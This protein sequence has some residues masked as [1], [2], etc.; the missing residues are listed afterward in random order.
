[1]K[2]FLVV[3]WVL[4]YSISYAQEFSQYELTAYAGLLSSFSESGPKKLTEVS[5]VKFLRPKSITFGGAL[6]I[7]MNKKWTYGIEV[8]YDEFNHGY[9]AMATQFAAPG[10]SS[11]LLSTNGRIAIYKTGVRW[12]YRQELGERFEVKGYLIPS[13]AYYKRVAAMDDTTNNNY[14]W[15]PNRPRPTEVWYMS[16]IPEQ[17]EGI[18]FLLKASAELVYKFKN[19]ISISLT[20]S[21]QQGFADFIVDYTNIMKPFDFSGPKEHLYWT[22]VDGTSF[23]GHFGIKYRFN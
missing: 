23:Q 9:K 14:W 16:Q 20:A 7:A 21:Y 19:R 22:K 3:V 10:L 13:I 6:D 5:P 15:S 2:G 1:M 11:G 12:G 18:Y 17:N 4:T 8:M